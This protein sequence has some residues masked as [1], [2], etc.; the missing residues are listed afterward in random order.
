MFD[1]QVKDIRGTGD[2][3]LILGNDVQSVVKQKL[4]SR[5]VVWQITGKAF[6]VFA[7]DFVTSLAELLRHICQRFAGTYIRNCQ[8]KGVQ[9]LGA[10][11]MEPSTD[12]YAIWTDAKEER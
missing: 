8:P 6:I 9:L 3:R 2:L 10:A 7:L 11:L 12:E 5:A 4:G 1:A